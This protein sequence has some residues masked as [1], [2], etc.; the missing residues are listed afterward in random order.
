MLGES[1]RDVDCGK[2][3][4]SAEE[5][6]VRDGVVDEGVVGDGVSGEG[7]GLGGAAFRMRRGEGRRAE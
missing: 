3:G 4:S 7:L 5:G 1:W 2:K 6:G